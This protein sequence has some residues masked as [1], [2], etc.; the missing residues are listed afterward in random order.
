MQ[1][2]AG[3]KTEVPEDLLYV[4]TLGVRTH[5]AVEFALSACEEHQAVMVV[6]DSL[7][8]AMVGDMAAARDV[9]ESRERSARPT[10][11]T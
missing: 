7:G 8:P 10:R 11:S 5:E 1:L 3:M 6:L 4:S 2:A 9:I